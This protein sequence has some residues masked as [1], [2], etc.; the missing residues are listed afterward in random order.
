M[1]T[2]RKTGD[3]FGTTGQLSTQNAAAQKLL[4]ASPTLCAR[5]PTY[6]AATQVRASVEEKALVHKNRRS[7][8][9]LLFIYK[10]FKE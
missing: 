6:F 2:V 4:S 9:L 10:A 5:R 1:R 7:L 3:S 8:L